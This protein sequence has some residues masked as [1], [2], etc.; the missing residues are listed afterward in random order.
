M[1]RMARGKARSLVAPSKPTLGA[2]TI[3]LSEGQIFGKPRNRDHAAMIMRTL[4]GKT[5]AVLTAVSVWN[6]TR[7]GEVLATASVTFRQLNDAEIAAYWDSGEPS[8]KAGGYGIQGLGAVF[9]R[10]V[11]ESPGTVAGLPLAETEQLLRQ[12][13]ISPWQPH[14]ARCRETTSNAGRS[15][16][17]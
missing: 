3:V 6:G 14:S 17:L 4:S 5:H 16:T 12:F 13:G 15:G 11:T 7:S 1:Q 8:D 9:I 2:D 10:S